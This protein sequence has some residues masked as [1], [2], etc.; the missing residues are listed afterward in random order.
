MSKYIYHRVYDDTYTIGEKG[1]PTAMYQIEAGEDFVVNYTLIEKGTLGGYILVYDGNNQY[2]L[3]ASWI[4]KHVYMTSDCRLKDTYVS[5]NCQLMSVEMTNTVV[6]NHTDQTH[7]HYNGV[8]RNSKISANVCTEHY[9]GV[10]IENSHVTTSSPLGIYGDVSITQSVLKGDFQIFG[11]DYPVEYLSPLFIRETTLSDYDGQIHHSLFRNDYL[12]NITI[13]DIEFIPQ[14]R[15]GT[16][17]PHNA[18]TFQLKTMKDL[19]FHHDNRTINI[20]KD[21]FGGSVHSPSQLKNSWVDKDTLLSKNTNLRD[22]Y[23]GSRCEFYHSDM[24]ESNN[25]IEH[26]IIGHDCVLEG[27]NTLLHVFAESGSHLTD[28][29]ASNRTFIGKYIYGRFEKTL[30]MEQV[31]D[32]FEDIY[33]AKQP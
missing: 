17:D 1:K 21:S 2:E 16:D 7:H 32:S 10:L 14:F 12:H 33:S 15:F 22:S 20:P 11:S 5:G 8:Y 24:S 19:T 25:Y 26:C 23:I 31:H 3:D 30:D 29:E 18:L 9:K 27:H 6:F 28:T 13:E 4:D